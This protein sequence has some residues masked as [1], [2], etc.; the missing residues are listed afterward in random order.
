MRIGCHELRRM[1]NSTCVPKVNK[2]G[3]E[4]A[5]S[6]HLLPGSTFLPGVCLTVG[7]TL[8]SVHTAAI[9]EISRWHQG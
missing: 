6:G 2:G 7:G 1:R 3:A 5:M 9:S 4:E 8:C